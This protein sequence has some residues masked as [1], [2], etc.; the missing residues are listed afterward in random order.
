[1]IRL[2]WFTSRCAPE[3]SGDQWRDLRQWLFYR[4]FP[5]DLL[6]GDEALLEEAVTV[7]V[8]KKVLFPIPAGSRLDSLLAAHHAMSSSPSPRPSAKLPCLGAS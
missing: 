3:V 5:A 2:L 4:G 1:M 7:R 6:L 8:T